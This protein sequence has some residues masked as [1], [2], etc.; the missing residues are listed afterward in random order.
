MQSF[1]GFIRLLLVLYL[2]LGKLIA[3]AIITCN[4]H[5]FRIRSPLDRYWSHVHTH[6]LKNSF[7]CTYTL[8]SVILHRLV[9]LF[10]VT[11]SQPFLV[12]TTTALTVI[13][14]TNEMK[15][16]L[17][18]NKI[19]LHLHPSWENQSSLIHVRCTC[20]YNLHVRVHEH[21]HVQIQCISFDSNTISSTCSL[22][23]F[24]LLFLF[25]VQHE[26]LVQ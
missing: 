2:V 10:V 4:N 16:Q 19:C 23:F 9:V 20:R 15:M 8:Y 3:R 13:A 14:N 11:Y 7:Y 21:E 1:C 24:L 6:T 12:F 25:I 17:I 5:H 18:W 22:I 26:H